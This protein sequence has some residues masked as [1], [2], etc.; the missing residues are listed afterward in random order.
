MKL[1]QHIEIE[2][3]RSLSQAKLQNLGRHTALVGKNSSGKSNVLRALNLFFNQESAPGVPLD[4]DRDLH[5]RPSRKQ[6]KR[7]S[8]A[9]DFTLPEKFNFRQGLE[10]LKKLGT[11]FRIRKV[12][13]LDRLQTTVR[14]EV[15]SNGKSRVDAEQVARE[16][17]S[18]VVFR[19]IP[20]RTVPAEMLRDESQAVAG[21]IFKKL[22]DANKA[23]DVLKGLSESAEKLLVSTA[24]A[25]RVAGAPLTEPNIATASTL[26][27][28]LSMT[29]FQAKGLNGAVVR[30]E[31]WGAGHQ[32]FFLLN[33]LREIDTD[34]S[35]QFGWRQACVWAV[36]EP[37][38]GLH[39]ELQT[40]LAQQ[41]MDW[42]DDAKRRLQ[43]ITTTHSPV[44]AMSADRGYWVEIGETSTDLRP[45]E[46][47]ELVRAA[48]NRGVSPYLHPAL[49]FPFHPVV[50]VEGPIDESVLN[51]VA[52]LVGRGQLRF[53]SLPSMDEDEPGAGIDSIINYV[54]RNK[55]VISR[56][57]VE[58]P[59]IVLADWD[60]S[61]EK[62]KRIG[63]A[64]G[65]AAS[66]LVLQQDENLANPALGKSFRGIERYYPERIIRAAHDAG[67]IAVAFPVGAAW[68]VSADELSRSKNRLMLRLMQT[69]DIEEL[70]HLVGLVEQCYRASV[71][72]ANEQLELLSRAKHAP[73]RPRTRTT[74]IQ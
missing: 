66:R 12:W 22:R 18:L 4:F 51:H 65:D 52:R 50:L 55:E 62:L 44:V 24:T 29:G 2:G 16:F 6:K 20:N 40:R 38:S 47:V 41:L 71:S 3:F 48:E 19:Y 45:C 68:S 46:I 17:L 53:M 32:A 10:H 69:H 30:D 64:F 57:Q 23:A 33:L 15:T 27:E 26:G 58:A 49:A 63:S 21:A 8:V 73:G 31:D 14:A 67:E 54:K 11:E 70:S 60:V 13:E 42:T 56:R 39:H 61:G 74:T 36:E 35:R 59:L 43:I 5:F 9:V 25:L 7:I 37:E 72:S 34:Y 1:L 28:M